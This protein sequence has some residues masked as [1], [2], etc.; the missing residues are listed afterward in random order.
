MIVLVHKENTVQN[1]AFLDGVSVALSKGSTV[2]HLIQLAQLYPDEWIG[3]SDRE[4]SAREWKELF[5]KKPTNYTVL[6]RGEAPGF[7]HQGI[8][9][10]EDSPYINFKVNN[11]Y[12]TWIMSAQMGLIHSSLLLLIPSVKMMGNFAYDINLFTRSVQSQ[13]VFCYSNLYGALE[14]SAKESSFLLYR[15]ISETQKKGWVF[16][17]FLCHLWMERRFPFLAFAKALLHIV[18]TIKIDLSMI[19]NS[20]A[21]EIIDTDYDVIIPT[22]GRAD[23]LKNVLKDLAEQTVLPQKVIIIEQDADLFSTTDL[24]YLEQE[25]WPF[26][27]THKFI[28]QTGA[29]NARNLGLKETDASWVLFFDDDIRFDHHLMESIFKSLQ[30]TRSLVINLCC[31]QKG[32]VENQKTYKQWSYFGSGCSIVHK[33]V[34]KQCSFD[35][36]LEHG[37]GEDVDYGMQIRK[38]GYDVIYAPQI[39][40]LH[41]KAP[42]GGF[43]KPHVFPWHDQKVLPKPSPQIMYY[44]KKNYTQ[45]QLLGYKMV[46]FFK[47]Y[48]VFDTKL[49]WMH[50]KKYKQAWEQSE[51]WGTQL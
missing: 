31:L 46:Q 2:E 51:K 6:S 3:W 9:Y 22:I 42:V 44:R 26:Q 19:Q 29:C 41:L 17:L 13:G 38:T 49:P 39:Q 21:L 43:R 16:L 33:D 12:P 27:I 36:A 8:D 40:I 15:F 11:W 24:H 48:G 47:T 5:E 23:Y 7:L 14:K 10:V 30:Q 34:I 18:K 1:K 50:Y 25:N 37:Y 45:R 35:M 32:E 4:R 28:H 20:S